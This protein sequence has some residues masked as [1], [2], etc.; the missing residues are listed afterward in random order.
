MVSK[1]FVKGIGVGLLMASCG[2]YVSSPGQSVVISASDVGNVH[3]E[4]VTTEFPY[5]RFKKLPSIIFDG[6]TEELVHHAVK[7]V[8]LE[9]GRSGVKV[10]TLKKVSGPEQYFI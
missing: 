2:I 7:R 9:D 10:I 5:S 4:L 8:T 1:A 6:E 3:G